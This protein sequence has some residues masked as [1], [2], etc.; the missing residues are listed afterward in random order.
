MSSPKGLRQNICNLL[1]PGA[2]KSE[3]DKRTIASCLPP[4]LQYACCYWVHHL[5]QS[6]RHIYNGNSI[7]LFLQKYL[8]Y[9]L[10]AMSLI[11]EVYKCIYMINSLQALTD[12]RLI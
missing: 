5:E 2:L 12:V 10:E 9:W 7:Y 3:I 11:G 4:E 1:I 6:K 8:L